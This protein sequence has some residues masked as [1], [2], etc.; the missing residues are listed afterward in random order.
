MLIGRANRDWVT[1]PTGSL[2]SNFMIAAQL[3]TLFAIIT[4]GFVIAAVQAAANEVTA[5]STGGTG[6]LTMCP[7]TGCNLYHHI[8]LPPKIAIGDKVPLRFGS[9][10]KDYNFPVARITRDG[11]A[12][13][14]YS[15]IGQTEKVEKIEVPS[16]QPAPGAQ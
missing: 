4:A 5:I 1:A 8:E 11:D 3:R 14:V 16:C 13:V 2:G 15:Q 10:P 12:C 6:D 7:Y 9:N